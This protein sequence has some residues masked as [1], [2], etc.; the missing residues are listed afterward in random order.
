VSTILNS[1]LLSHL[2]LL[3]SLHHLIGNMS[4]EIWSLQSF[5]LPIIALILLA[6]SSHS[7]TNFNN[8]W[9]EKATELELSQAYLIFHVHLLL[10]P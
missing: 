4:P 1:D 10:R 8:V 5:C 2:L 3:V 6:I 9:H 7:S